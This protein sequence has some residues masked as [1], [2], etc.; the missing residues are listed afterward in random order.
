MQKLSK[1]IDPVNFY[2]ITT[3]PQLYQLLAEATGGAA[4]SVAE[5]LSLL[6]DSIMD[7]Y[8]SLPQVEEEF[9]DELYDNHLPNIK[10]VEITEVSETAVKI[11][12]EMSGEK[13]AVFLNDGMIGIVD[14]TELTIA[15]LRR[16]AETTISL[17]PLSADRRGETVT[18]TLPALAGRGG[19]SSSEMI[20]N[21]GMVDDY[22]SHLVTAVIPKAPNTGVR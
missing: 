14:S 17:V 18:K 9:E 8:D 6:T 22:K 3:E 10:N 19:T 13:T 21:N 15:D 7:R 11:N 5:D 16:D 1:Q 2:I 12:F 20:N 4:V